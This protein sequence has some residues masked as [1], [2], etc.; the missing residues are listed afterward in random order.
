MSSNDQLYPTDPAD[1]FLRLFWDLSVDG[2]DEQIDEWVQD[3][4]TQAFA[5]YVEAEALT[6]GGFD[7]ERLA[8]EID[9]YPDDVRERRFSFLLGLD[10]AFAS[11]HPA[12]DAADG[13]HRL[14]P[15]AS[16]YRELGRF[17]SDEA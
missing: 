17:N 12:I 2:L 9:E 3:D 13:G 6:R 11:V 15:L 10:R 4:A 8:D 1:L 5:D 14:L 7:P 16:R